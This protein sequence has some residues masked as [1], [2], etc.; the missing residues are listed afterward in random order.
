MSFTGQGQV[1]VSMSSAAGMQWLKDAQAKQ[2]AE[3]KLKAKEAKMDAAARV[4]GTA[5]AF[6]NNTTTVLSNAAT[7]GATATSDLQATANDWYK[8]VLISIQEKKKFKSS[9]DLLCKIKK[10][11]GTQWDRFKGMISRESTFN[12]WWG[13]VQNNLARGLDKTTIM[14]QMMTIETNAQKITCPGPT[15]GAIK[16][17][18]RSLKMSRRRQNKGGKKS[19]RRNSRKMRKRKTKRRRSNKY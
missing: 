6:N 8:Y 5:A 15:G 2:K 16:N 10:T 9:R 4:V 19:K 3:K 18:L 7:A 1:G 17:K 13:T 11:L 14:K 12:R